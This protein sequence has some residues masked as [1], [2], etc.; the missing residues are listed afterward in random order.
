MPPER[1]SNGLHCAAK[2][3]PRG[4]SRTLGE[5]LAS[6]AFMALHDHPPSEAT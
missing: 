5:P 3:D 2:D 6:P 4:T 1:V